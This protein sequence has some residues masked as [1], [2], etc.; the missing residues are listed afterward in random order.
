MSSADTVNASLD[1]PGVRLVAHRGAS[2][3]APENSLAAFAAAV[4]IGVDFVE[5][6]YRHSID[7]VPIVYHDEAL[8]RLTNSAEIFEEQGVRLAAKTA[9]E[10]SKLRIVRDHGGVP[11][12]AA[13]ADS[14]LPTLEE[15][16][17]LI[18]SQALT[19]IER[20]AGDAATLVSLLKRLG[21][22]ERVLVQAFDWSFLADCRRLAPEMALGALGEGILTEDRLDQ[23]AQVVPRVIG[24]KNGDTDRETIRAIHSHGMK[25]WVWTVDD[26]QRAQELLSWGLDGL[27]TNV[28]A[29]MLSLCRP[30]ST[31]V[32]RTALL[33]KP[34]SSF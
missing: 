9:A 2:R 3:A 16:L 7:G 29:T 26:P 21:Q 17:R 34:S 27:I 8:D 18:Q 12:P 24:W 32:V 14:G 28:P 11:T 6:D 25:A 15:A 20:K 1:A 31:S 23:A 10:I 4:A 13:F 30:C 22:I 5:L 33:T 19:M